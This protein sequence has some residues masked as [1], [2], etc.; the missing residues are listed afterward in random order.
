MSAKKA[1]LCGVFLQSCSPGGRGFWSIHGLI[2]L[3]LRLFFLTLCSVFMKSICSKGLENLAK[4]SNVN[5]SACVKFHVENEWEIL[6]MCEIDEW[7]Y[8]PFH[9]TLNNAFC[10]YGKASSFQFKN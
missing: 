8:T 10:V 7:W 5:F 4:N 6:R 2:Q 9:F 1:S 3:L